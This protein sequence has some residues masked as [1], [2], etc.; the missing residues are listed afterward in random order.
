MEFGSE[1]NMVSDRFMYLPSFG[2]CFALGYGLWKAGEVLSK[3]FSLR[4]LAAGIFLGV[5]L[6]ASLSVKGRQ[7]VEVWKDSESFWSHQLAIEP[8]PATVLQLYQLGHGMMLK[9]GLTSLTEELP[10]DR[11]MSFDLDS[12]RQKRIERIENL[13][14]QALALKPD[15]DTVYYYRGVIALR[16]GNTAQAKENWQQTLRINPNHF[17]TLYAWGRM[18]LLQGEPQ[19]AVEAFRRAIKTIP[20]HTLLREDILEAYQDR[21]NAGDPHAEIYRRE[22]GRMAG[23]N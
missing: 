12:R 6:I 16:L 7:Q 10:P 4:I 22:M 11:E 19:A 20:D 21:I 9:E 2:I 15:F 5:V 18:E 17:L 1:M 8:R 23:G 3:R 13:F 14:A